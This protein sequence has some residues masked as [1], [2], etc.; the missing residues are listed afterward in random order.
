MFKKFSAN[1]NLHFI[2]IT[3]ITLIITGLILSAGLGQSHLKHLGAYLSIGGLGVIFIYLFTILIYFLTKK[4]VSLTKK[5]I[6]IY[7]GSSSFITI[8]GLISALLNIPNGLN[9]F[10][11]GLSLFGLFWIGTLFFFI[12]LR[13]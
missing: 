1:N 8:G 10:L 12:F 7:L 9:L 6:T 4:E 13:K 11:F 5:L 3:G 2:P